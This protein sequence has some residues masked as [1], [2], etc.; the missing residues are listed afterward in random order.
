MNFNKHVVKNTFTCSPQNNTNM[1]INN[2]NVC[3]TKLHSVC[4]PLL[5]V[6]RQFHQVSSILRGVNTSYT[7]CK[8]ALWPVSIWSKHWRIQKPGALGAY[9]PSI[10]FAEFCR[11]RFL[12]KLY[13]SVSHLPLFSSFKTCKYRVCVLFIYLSFYLF[14]YFSLFIC[15]ENV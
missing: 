9:V 13:M 12:R 10:K 1:S 7:R 4:M 5:R 8:I 3:A 6:I 2:P 14:I 11:K 15:Q